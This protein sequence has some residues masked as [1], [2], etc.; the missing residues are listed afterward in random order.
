MAKQLAEANE[1]SAMVQ[2]NKATILFDCGKEKEAL[3]AITEAIRLL[4]TIVRNPEYA[5]LIDELAGSYLTRGSILS[6]LG[7]EDSATADFTRSINLFRPLINEQKRGELGLLLAMALRSRGALLASQANY[8]SGTED[9]EAAEKLLRGLIK[10][11]NR[12]NLSAE[13]AI[14]WTASGQ[15]VAAASRQANDGKRLLA[16]ADDI[17]SESIKLFVWLGIHAPRL[18]YKQGHAAA[19]SS[20][21]VVRYRLG[22]REDAKNDLEAAITLLRELNARTSAA[23]IRLQLSQ[24]ILNLGIGLAESGDAAN[25]LSRIS[26]GVD[27]QRELVKA[28]NGAAEVALAS[29]LQVRG[30]VYA[31]NGN[32]DSALKDLDESITL[33]RSLMGR[34]T[35]TDLEGLLSRSTRYRR[36]VADGKAIPGEP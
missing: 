27:I 29:S 13:M 17:F 15:L 30:R 28:G 12:P 36:Y 26:S 20:R 31:K 24:C 6:G 25:G 33:C 32:K 16:K 10:E 9:L 4:E 5:F 35:R 7:Q 34:H 2:H 19:L 1:L 8:R 11:E 18:Q 3:A 22:R 23:E 14:V 21:S